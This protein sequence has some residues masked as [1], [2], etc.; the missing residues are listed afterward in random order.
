MKICGDVY[1]VGDVVELESEDE[2]WLGQLIALKMGPRRTRRCVVNWFYKPRDVDRG[3]TKGKV[4]A[5]NEVFFSEHRDDNYVDCITRR[6]RVHLL[7]PGD[8]A[9][10]GKGAD[11][12]CRFQYHARPKGKGF[13]APLSRSFWNTATKSRSFVCGSPQRT[14]AAA[15]A[16]HQ[17]QVACHGQRGGRHR[18]ART[19]APSVGHPPLVHHSSIL[20]YEPLGKGSCGSAN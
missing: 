19:R 13:L 7:N 8:T 12:V 20:F 17:A 6:V 14:P 15:G 1:H 18:A 11:Y 5:A 2:L 3:S 16:T 9:P 4:L 10:K